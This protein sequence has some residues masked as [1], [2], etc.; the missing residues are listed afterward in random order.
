[1][2]DFCFGNRTTKKFKDCTGRITD[3]RTP[4]STSEAGLGI[5]GE[6]LEPFG[7]VSMFDYPFCVT[8]L[9]REKQNLGDEPATAF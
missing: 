9:I 1:M 2:I 6:R 5:F 7:T 8:A 4:N 3:K